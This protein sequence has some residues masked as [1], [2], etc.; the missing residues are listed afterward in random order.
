M[1]MALKNCIQ[2]EGGF[3]LLKR[4]EFITGIFRLKFL[5]AIKFC[6]NI[7]GHVDLFQH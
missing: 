4:V 1:L 7:Q 6:Q 2:I 5:K 3:T